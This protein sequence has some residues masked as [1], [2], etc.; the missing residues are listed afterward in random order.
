MTVLLF[1][2]KPFLEFGRCFI[3]VSAKYPVKN[4]NVT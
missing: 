1:R 3:F 4:V 2:G